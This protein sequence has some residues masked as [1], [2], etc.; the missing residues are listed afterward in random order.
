MNYAFIQAILDF[1]VF[2]TCVEFMERTSWFV[3][4]TGAYI[5]AE[6]IEFKAFIQYL[7]IYGN[8]IVFSNIIIAMIHSI[9]I[10]LKSRKA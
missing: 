1:A 4:I 2:F 7:Y 5:N 9:N 6:I 3:P 10:F 8:A